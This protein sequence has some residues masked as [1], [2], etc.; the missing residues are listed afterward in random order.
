MARALEVAART[1]RRWA[2]GDTP[3]PDW[4]PAKL[5][6]LTGAT[7]TNLTTDE[8]IVGSDADH[9]RLYVLHTMH[10]R[11]VARLAELDPETDRPTAQDVDVAEDSVVYRADID[12]ALAELHWID[13]A[14]SGH[15]LTRLMEA[16]C[17]AVERWEA[18]E[19]GIDDDEDD[20]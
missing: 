14:P 9:V 10:P 11:F 8:W 2:S 17:D 3:I 20:G 5:A 6:A 19:A 7:R 1:V 13:P 12:V 18:V 15:D 4:L 16:A